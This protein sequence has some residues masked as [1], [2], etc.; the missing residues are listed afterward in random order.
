[1]IKPF[2]QYDSDRSPWA[3]PAALMLALCGWSA[4]AL[5]QPQPA[6]N[7]SPA[8]Q[9][10]PAAEE[11]SVTA[12]PQ[13]EA[14]LTPVPAP[15]PTTQAPVPVAS[16]I[17]PDAPLDQVTPEA[18]PLL[19][20][21]PEPEAEEE[22]GPFAVPSIEW[23]LRPDGKS[24]LRLLTWSQ[25]WL[26]ATELNPGTQLKNSDSDVIGDFGI[27]RARML[28]FGKITPEVLVLLHIGINNQTFDGDR[29]PQLFVHDA[30]GQ[31]DVFDNYLTVGAGLHYWNGISR[32]SNAST[33]KFMGIDAP[34]LNW[35]TIDLNDQFARHL[36][37]FAKGQLGRLDYRVAVNKPFQIDAPANLG[38]GQTAFDSGSQGVEFAGYVQYMFG[39][40]ESNLLPYT[41]GT[42]LGSK[43]VFNLG[44]GAQYQANA[45]AQC[46]QVEDD[47]CV[48]TERHDL[49][50][51]GADVFV[52][53]PLSGGSAVTAYGAYYYYD[54]GPDYVRQVGIMPIGSGGSTVNGAGNRYP[55][56][57]TGHHF[58]GQ[59]G[60][61]L[62]GRIG[63]TQLQPY[64][65]LQLSVM[66]GL[67]DPVIV[68]E[69]GVNWF[70]AGH[71]TKLTAHY[72]NRPIFVASADKPEEDGRAS[73][74]IT[75]LQVLF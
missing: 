59:A 9:A 42:Y 17:S 19:S 6:T 73:E 67:A 40:I 36:G 15:A 20:P 58:Y 55:V 74:L 72:R 10:A 56:L 47:L 18:G 8:E 54:F 38:E 63:Q 68:P 62:P 51:F 34:I 37:V 2:A 53:Q 27:R 22:D 70:I 30:W 14:A 45:M 50:L 41:V 75:Q 26:R 1:M 28:L 65:A 16:T 3:R 61:L 60:F 39:E 64:A 24:Y 7:D 11:T 12:A 52:D 33:L 44:V 46:E 71:N 23:K 48:S 66:E 29:K 43:R 21:L 32:M 31:L 13:G 4:A 57:G 25:F 35:P 49:S 5:A 69:V